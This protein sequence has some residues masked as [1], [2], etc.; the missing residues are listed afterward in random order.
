LYK[1]ISSIIENGGKIYD[2]YACRLNIDY[3]GTHYYHKNYLNYYWYKNN[4]HIPDNIYDMLRILFD[5]ICKLIENDN[6]DILEGPKEYA[7]NFIIACSDFLCAECFNEKYG[8]VQQPK[9]FL[10]KTI[11]EVLYYKTMDQLRGDNIKELTSMME[12]GRKFLT[13]YRDRVTGKRY[14]VRLIDFSKIDVGCKKYHLPHYDNNL[15]YTECDKC[16]YY[17]IKLL[18]YLNELDEIEIDI[19]K[20]SE[21]NI[22]Y[23][24]DEKGII[25][26]YHIC[27]DNNLYHL[28]HFITNSSKKEFSI[29]IESIVSNVIKGN[30]TKNAR[31]V[32]K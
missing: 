21:Y 16:S 9:K 7:T 23:Q 12:S 19:C 31:S 8:H 30:K 17:Y 28:L 10:N 22:Y 14:Y 25:F 4:E 29:P 3:Y 6:L 18:P 15:L 24:S 20:I 13:I 1:I 26:L 32:K 5:K 2:D 27:E 11:E